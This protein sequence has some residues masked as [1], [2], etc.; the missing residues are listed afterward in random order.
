VSYTVYADEVRRVISDRPHQ[1]LVASDEQ[2]FIQF[3]QHEFGQDRVVFLRDAPRSRAGG[4]AIHFDR[5]AGVSNY[6][7]GK[8][9]LMDCL[10]L[11]AADY[12]IKGRSNLSDAS[13]VFN[14]NLPYSFCPL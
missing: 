1:I 10:L 12:L 9:G 11:S 8:A 4:P 13:L 14:P 7:K 5:R 2:E 6:A 3:M